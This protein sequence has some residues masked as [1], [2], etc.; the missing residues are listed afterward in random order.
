[1][2]RSRRVPLAVVLALALVTVV[3]WAGRVVWDRFDRT[4]LEQ[5]LAAVPAE[6]QRVTWTD[7][8]VVRGALGRDGDL[9]DTP[10]RDEV[11][12]M[13]AAA[14]DRDL[15][16]ASAVDEAA[17]AMQ[18]LFGFGPGTAQW[19]AFGQSR[20]GNALV[21]RLPDGT[22][23]DVIGDNLERAGFTRPSGSSPVWDGGPDLIASLDLTLTPIVQYVALLPDEG[24]VV[25]SDEQAYA[26]S[27]ADVGSGALGVDGVPSLAERLGDPAAAVLW[28]GDFV[29]DDLAMASAD[30]TAQQQAARA[31]EAAGGLSPLQGFALGL[32]D[33]AGLRVVAHLED[34]DR[35]ERDLRPRAELAAGPA[36]GRS[37]D[38]PDDFEITRA[39]TLGSD[40]VLD[41]RP[42]RD[43]AFLLS[44]LYDGPLV[45]AGC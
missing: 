9:G 37:G 28:T 20:E 41:L 40:V 39:R 19:E 15:A 10:D 11:D 12:A 14:Y 7:W 4:E 38:F 8:R 23:F 33:A 24:L 1:M 30:P 18:E 44:G 16:A 17:G 43:G 45:F 31:V 13:V 42:T 3:A 25:A 22:D 26:A 21:L 6:S 29:C 5:A 36:Y 35:A 27:S 32:D 2:G 34:A